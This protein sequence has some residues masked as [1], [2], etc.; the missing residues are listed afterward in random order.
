MEAN[1]EMLAI[2]QGHIQNRGCLGSNPTFL[3]I[4]RQ[5]LLTLKNIK[6]LILA[7]T[8]WHVILKFYVKSKENP[9]LEGVCKAYTYGANLH[10]N[11]ILALVIHAALNLL[12]NMI[13][14]YRKILIILRHSNFFSKQ[15]FKIFNAKI[16]KFN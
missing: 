6:S 10:I 14:Q 3:G 7:Y 2:A 15:K 4:F 12:C 1:K 16:W 8:T 13:F 11:T 5:V 9:F